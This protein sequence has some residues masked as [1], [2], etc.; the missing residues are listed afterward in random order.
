MEK[1]GYVKS[2]TLYWIVQSHRREQ[3]YFKNTML[4]PSS[5]TLATKQKFQACMI[6]H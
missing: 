4:F 3:I 5:E 6:K 1:H 2:V